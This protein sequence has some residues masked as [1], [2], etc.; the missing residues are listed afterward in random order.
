MVKVFDNDVDKALRILRK[1]DE[2][3]I[4]EC[5]TRQA[6]RSEKDRR[7]EKD[8]KAAKRRGWKYNRK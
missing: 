6:F 5:I 7:R 3:K 2:W 8:F 1:Q 4:H